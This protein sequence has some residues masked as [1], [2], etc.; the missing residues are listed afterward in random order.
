MRYALN[1]PVDSIRRHTVE[2][3][4][5]VAYGFL[6]LVASG[7][8]TGWQIHFRH[9]Q[10]LSPAGYARFFNC[11][12]LLGQAEDAVL[13]PTALLDVKID[14]TRGD[15]RS[16]AERFLQH[17]IRRFPL[18]IGRQVETLVDRQLAVGGGSIMRIAEQLGLQHRTLQRRLACQGLLFEDIVDGV[19]RNR[20]EEYLPHRDIPLIQIAALLGYNNQTSLNRSCLRWFGK[21]PNA[22]RVLLNA[23]T[24]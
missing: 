1:L 6:K 13:F 7:D 12:V 16:S 22:L 21:P 2:L 15:L 17:V 24:T 20:A 11:P 19:R 4:Y 5:A 10:G 18:D 8:S 3:S 14:S 9:D 23:V